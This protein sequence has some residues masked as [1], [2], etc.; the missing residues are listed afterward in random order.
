MVTGGFISI[1]VPVFNEGHAVEL[2]LAELTSVAV[3]FPFRY[4]LIFVNDGS[5]DDT[6]ERI[7]GSTCEEPGHRNYRFF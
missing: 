5:G 7:F 3:S 1:V 2:F 6:R 4:E